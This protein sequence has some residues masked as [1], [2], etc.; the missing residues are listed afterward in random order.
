[1]LPREAY[2]RCGAARYMTSARTA[3]LKESIFPPARYREVARL[4]HAV[5]PAFDEK[6]FLSHALKGLDAL[7]LMQRLRRM[8]ESMHVA[9][10]GSFR[11]NLG[12][13]RGLAPRM[14]A[15]FATL[16]LPDYVALHGRGDPGVS[17]EALRFFTRFG[18]AEFAIRE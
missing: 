7:S 17:L 1:R 9:L 6:L 3:T 13:L 12:I 8:T 14:P 18:S 4:A 2:C 10:P 5:Y 16:F 11:R 15:G